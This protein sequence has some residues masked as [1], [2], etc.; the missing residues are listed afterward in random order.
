MLTWICIDKVHVTKVNFL[1]INCSFLIQERM[2]TNNLF[3]KNN[4][5]SSNVTFVFWIEHELCVF[6]RHCFHLF[7]L[8]NCLIIYNIF[9]YN[10]TT[11]IAKI[12]SI[13]FIFSLLIQKFL[14]NVHQ[15]F[16]RKILFKSPFSWS[17]HH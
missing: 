13:R 5:M 8:R 1:S 11:D 9:F 14:N 7:F 15:I 3:C 4:G 10:K 12:S 17:W 16:H 6:I 2:L